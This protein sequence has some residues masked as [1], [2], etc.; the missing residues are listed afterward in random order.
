MVNR[1][2]TKPL[3]EP[4]GC[5]GYILLGP[6]LTQPT[7]PRTLIICPFI[8]ATVSIITFLSL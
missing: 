4:W 5:A 3:V 7:S 8:H 6:G 2:I 1:P